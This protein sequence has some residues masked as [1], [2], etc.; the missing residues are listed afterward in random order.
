MR[1][2]S[3][4]HLRGLG[5]LVADINRLMRKEFDRRVR[6]LGLTRSQWLFISYLTR[7]PGCT[8]SE[9]AE[10]LQLEKITVSRQAA[11]LVKAG[12]ISRRDHAADGR[13]YR[14]HLAPRARRMA[15]RLEEVATALRCDYL[16][17]VAPARR[18]AL[19]D[20]LLHI[21][22][23]LQRMDANGKPAFPSS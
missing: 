20:D 21:K 9:L 19:R 14:L 11:R 23:N 1:Q 4:D 7:L 5:F 3:H 10:A 2:R 8:Q 17:G 16:R 18:F 15:E 12:W 13:A 22:A 6:H